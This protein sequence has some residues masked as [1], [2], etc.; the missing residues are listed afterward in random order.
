MEFLVECSACSAR[1]NL[2]M[3]HC[4]RDGG[5]WCD[6]CWE[7]R[8]LSN[9]RIKNLQRY[10]ERRTTQEGRAAINEYQRAYYYTKRGLPVPPLR[11]EEQASGTKKSKKCGQTKPLDEFQRTEYKGEIRYYSPCQACATE[12]DRQRRALAQRNGHN[13]KRSKP[14][15]DSAGWKYIV[16]SMD[17]PTL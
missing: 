12:H 5:Y 3:C 17:T 11:G 4:S 6:T 2:E 1:I 15:I 10:H 9:A 7:E 8:R 14:K 16:K 13:V